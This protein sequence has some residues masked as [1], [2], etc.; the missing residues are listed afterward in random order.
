MITIVVSSVPFGL[1]SKTEVLYTMNIVNDL[2]GS[3]KVSNYRVQ[4][5]NG[6]EKEIW[7]GRGLRHRRKQ[8]IFKLLD[9]AIS[10]FEKEGGD[11]TQKLRTM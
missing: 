2:T 8:G 10:Q 4:I 5:K 3:P 9:L 1:K 6:K 11:H 7:H